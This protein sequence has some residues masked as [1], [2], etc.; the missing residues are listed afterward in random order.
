MLEREAKRE[1][2]LENMAKEKRLKTQQVRT[3]SAK[4]QT[5]AISVD[6]MIRRAEEEFTKSAQISG[7]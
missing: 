5:G 6:E 4:E 1:K 2:L 3:G 7:K